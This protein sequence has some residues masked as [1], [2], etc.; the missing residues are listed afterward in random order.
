MTTKRSSL[1]FES[2]SLDNIEQVE[3]YRSDGFHPVSI[4][5][6]FANGRYRILHKLGFGGFSTCL[7]SSR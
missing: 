6:R 5:D 7:V 3:N 2:S 4:G 1:R